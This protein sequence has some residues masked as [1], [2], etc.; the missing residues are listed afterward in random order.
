MNTIR[1]QIAR[2]ELARDALADLC[3][4]LTDP[5]AILA[6][7]QPVEPDEMPD[8]FGRLLLHHDHMTTRLGAFYGRPVALRI[9]RQECVGD[10]YRRLIALLPRGLDRVVEVGL[11][12]ID[13]SCTTPEVRGMILGG[14]TPLGD[15][16][17]THNVLRR[18]EPQWYFRFEPACPLMAHFDAALPSAFGRVGVIHCDQRPAIRLLEIVSGVRT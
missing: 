9:L 6:G 13:L 17:I 14:V 18:I 5:T 3:A 8:P 1:T 11:V 10:M 7:S 12:Q 15:V 2:S 16:L 4:G